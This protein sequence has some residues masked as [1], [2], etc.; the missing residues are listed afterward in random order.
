MP[1][2]RIIYGIHFEYPDR[3]FAEKPKIRGRAFAKR[4]CFRG[5]DFNVLS[6]YG[7]MASAL[8]EQPLTIIAQPVTAG[9]ETMFI[10][11]HLTARSAIAI[12]VMDPV[13]GRFLGLADGVESIY[14][15]HVVFS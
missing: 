4:V 7:R 10:L 1:S 9:A 12:I 14:N 6:G 15:W 11:R 2:R 13:F 3:D 8:L 5:D